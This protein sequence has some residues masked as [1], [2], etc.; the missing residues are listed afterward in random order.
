MAPMTSGR[1]HKWIS[2]CRNF[3]L[4]GTSLHKGFPCT[5]D[6]PLFYTGFPFTRVEISSPTIR[7]S[8][9]HARARVS[10]VTRVT[11]HAV[12]PV[13]KKKTPPEKKTLGKISLQ[14]AKSVA[15]EQFLPADCMAKARR[16]GVFLLTDTGMTIGTWHAHKCMCVCSYMV[17]GRVGRA[18]TETRPCF[19]ARTDVYRIRVHVYVYIY[20]YT[21][22][23][24]YIYI[25]IYIYIYMYTYVY[26]YA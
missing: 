5:S 24:V 26:I 10:L 7:T 18:Q 22:M 17:S 13:S 15:G 20:I 1:R 9:E 3:P 14:K 21:H 25:H 19:E 8:S 6:F 16:K 4:E 12:L 2:L 11:T 23:C